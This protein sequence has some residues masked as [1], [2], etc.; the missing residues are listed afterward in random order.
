M[1]CKFE[2]W[3]NKVPQEKTATPTTTAQNITPDEGK[4]LSKVAVGAIQTETKTVTV[5]GDVTPSTGKYLS[6]VTV[7][8]PPTPTQEKTAA[9]TENG[10]KTVTPDSGKVLSKVTITTNVPSVD[11]VADSA[12][13][14][15]KLVE[16][17][18]GRAYRFTGETDDKYVKGDLY[19]VV[20][21]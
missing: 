1:A 12:T 8:V 20:S 5:N 7:N 11:D 15:A 17:N 14:D 2:H 6:K 9:I 3:N 13:L 4:Y 21:E 18:A 19:L 10:T 16:A